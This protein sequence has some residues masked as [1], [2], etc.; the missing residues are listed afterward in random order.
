[1]PRPNWKNELKLK[2]CRYC[3]TKEGLTIDHKNPISRGGGNG[4]KNLQCLCWRCNQTKG[5]RTEGEMQ[6]LWVF[7]R[8]VDQ[9]RIE[10]GKQPRFTKR[11]S[12][13]IHDTPKFYE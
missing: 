10:R 6:K 12:L 7:F 2:K 3:L 9:E 1:M 8:Q 4:R 5:N 11:K 13:P